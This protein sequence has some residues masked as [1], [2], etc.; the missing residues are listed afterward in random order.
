MAVQQLTEA[1]FEDKVLKAGKPV[2]V[3]FFKYKA[4]GA[5]NSSKRMSKV[6]DDWASSESKADFFRMPL[7]DSPDVAGRYGVQ[8]APTLL[9]FSKG[10]KV[11]SS[12]ATTMTNVPRPCWR[13]ICDEA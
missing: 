5:E 3:E 7:S 4:D 6:L 2:V 8:S 12:S 10:S 11:K 1:Q 9:Y 13:A